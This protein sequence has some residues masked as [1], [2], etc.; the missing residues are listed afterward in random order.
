MRS[1]Q[2]TARWIAALLLGALSWAMTGMTQADVKGT[3]ALQALIEADWIEQDRLFAESQGTATDEPAVTTAEDASGGCDGVKN[4]RWG[5]HTASGEIDPWWQVD[6][7]REQKLG[8]IVV[9]NRVDRGCARR[10]K[11][12][13]VSVA[14]DCD[15]K[16]FEEVYRHEGEA[17]HG[18]SGG[19]PL[20]VDLQNKDVSARIV[21]LS[22]PG[23]CSFALDEIEVYAAEDLETNLALGRPADQKSVGPYSYPG[24][25]PEGVDRATPPIENAK[26]GG[27]SFAHIRQVLDRAQRLA[28]RL[29]ATA[30]VGAIAK[31]RVQLAKMEKADATS[32][33]DRRALYFAARQL[34]RQIAFTNPLFDFDKVLFV[35]R[36][37]SVGVFHMCDQYYGCNGKPGGGLFVLHDP[38]GKPRVENRA[39]GFGG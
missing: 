31:L 34:A 24:T 19:E 23:K 30:N 9:F 26:G 22:I 12:L 37:D 7:G 14:C 18:V 6:L 13:V 33:N 27:F 21:R 36:H 17:F 15:G 4:G 16:K 20:V 3:S 38:F 11:N 5:F 1:Y 39:G 10:T 28:A 2:A 29:Q 25:L 32:S 35:K 8:R